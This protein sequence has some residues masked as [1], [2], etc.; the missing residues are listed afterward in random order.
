MTV[1]SEKRESFV[2]GEVFAGRYRMIARIG[3]GGMGEV[4]RADDL[5]L[6][7]PVA[8]KL[9]LSNNPAAKERMVKEVR[10]ARQI[11]HP[12]VCRV[13][14]VGESN[15]Q[16][17]LTMELVAGE[18]LSTLLHHV[19]RL[20]SE[21]VSE[22]GQQLC[23]GLAAAHAQGVLH[24]DLKPANILIDDSGGIHITDFGIAILRAESAAHLPIGTPEYMAPE[25]LT[26]GAPL[27]EQ[28]DLYA[29]GLVLYELITGAR[30]RVSAG[31]QLPRPSSLAPN[32]DPRLERAIVRATATKPID[33]PESATA[34][35]AALPGGEAR[36]SSGYAPGSR[37]RKRLWLAGAVVA[38]VA[39]AAAGAQLYFSRGASALT[40]RDTV[41]IA[42]FSNTTG[43]PIFDGAM[44]V[45]LAV[46]LEQSPFLKVFP[47]E[48]VRET[49]RL[50][51]RSPDQPVD[52]ATAR[53]VARREQIK[54]LLAG[55]IGRIGSHYVLALEAVNA[56]SG[57]VMA[58]EQAEVAGKEEV[59]TGLGR[60]A[61]RLREKLGESL[62]SVEKYDVP[63]PR[64]TT[65][66]LEALQAYALALDEGRMDPRREVIPRLK[67]AI[68]ID[69]DFAMAQATLSGMYANM[70][71]SALAPALSKRAF[72][73]RD[74]VSERE[75]FYISWRYYR[76]ATQQWDKA[77]EL[78][79]SW[80]ATYP[81]ESIA[82]NSL[83]F[84]A[85]S[86]GQYERALD[87]LREAI[88]LD[89]RSIAP[90]ENLSVALMA[91]NRFDEAKQVLREAHGR[92]KYF[93]A[94]GRV[95]YLLG[96]LDRDAAEMTRALD[97]AA[98][99]PE[100]TWAANWQPRTFAFLGQLD[101]AHRAFRSGV[102]A[103]RQ[104]NLHEMAAR[105]ST[106]DAES[107]AV[108]GQCA[109][110]RS[111][112]ASG[113]ALSRD[114][115]TLERASRT[116]ALCGAADEASRL[117][118]E[119]TKRYPDAILTLRV[120][121]PVAMAAIASARGDYPRVVALLEP[122]RAFDQVTSAEFWPQYLRGQALLQ[123]KEGARARQ[124]F[125]GILEHRGTAPDGVLY[126]LA[127]L[128]LARAAM[129][130]GDVAAARQATQAF[131]DFWKDADPDLAP[132]KDARELS[133]RL[134]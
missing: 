75:R 91:L 28:T 113:L 128:G 99:V 59:L 78:A 66:S 131:L 47:D 42:D 52:R 6:Q 1:P 16:V 96:F 83:G 87:P 56:E 3:R 80:T 17:F 101:A 65:P 53:E 76:D 122:V 24:R 84:A 107:H 115:F 55:S 118:E 26:T 108:L 109:P 116:L 103:V 51:E 110:V 34:L 82:F 2:S 64:A 129:A 111:E 106:E 95:S 89:P 19:G 37:S 8:L 73:L 49:L 44:K 10:L 72:D 123:L 63:L 13:F 25:Q 11:T 54:A 27:T 88:R 60:V 20:P 40:E 57:D 22:I 117:I 36:E 125:Q 134:Q 4:W 69:P 12:A 68:E 74:R 33:R 50:M 43:E 14:D 71:Q 35:A 132:L 79:Q 124:E 7:T 114:N 46:A 30:P 93:V 94:Q 58:R 90:P 121:V 92:Q 86:L 62:A 48:R 21:K 15:G 23:A 100:S 61:A 85:L 126:P 105:F 77:L 112:V 9:I 29:L 130:T 41:V 97:E 18:D 45:A 67:R 98:S 81:R 104:Q 127:E 32:I 119:L 39:L 38:A 5:V 102:E 120:Q 31:G 70:G 133:A